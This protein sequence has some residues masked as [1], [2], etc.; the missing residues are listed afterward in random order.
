MNNRRPRASALAIARSLAAIG[1]PLALAAC[2]PAAI[3]SVE[4][5]P[6][7]RT[8]CDTSIIPNVCGV[9]DNQPVL[10]RVHG[11]GDCSAVYTTC[12]NGSNGAPDG[13]SHDFGQAPADQPL[14]VSCDYGQSYPGPKTIKAHSNGSDCIGEAT[15]RI[16]VMDVSASG[17]TYRSRI[18]F[19]QP[20]PTTC[21][22][23][24]NRRPLRRGTRVKVQADPNPIFRTSYGCVSCVYDADGE[25][26]SVAPPGFPFKGLRKYS[27]VLRIGPQVAQGGTNETFDVDPGGLLEICVNDDQLGD[28]SGSWRIDLSVDESRAP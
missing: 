3:S 10:L 7:Q 4:L 1:V 28:N 6:A 5:D 12:G 19:H 24:P 20:T 15:L 2:A 16:N 25:P 26:G 9:P 22:V 17:V 27:L 21:E 18:G 8:V 23:L 14:R 11:K 13:T